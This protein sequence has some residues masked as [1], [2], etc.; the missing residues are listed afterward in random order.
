MNA[1]KVGA[2][3]SFTYQ[4]GPLQTLNGKCGGVLNG[5]ITS[6]GSSIGCYYVGGAVG[7]IFGA[8]GGTAVL[9]G[10]GSVVGAAE[11]ATGAAAALSALCGLITGDILQNVQCGQDANVLA[12]FLDTSDTSGLSSVPLNPPRITPGVGANSFFRV[13]GSTLKVCTDCSIVQPGPLP[14]CDGNNPCAALCA[15]GDCRSCLACDIKYV[16]SYPDPTSPT[17][18]SQCQADICSYFPGEKFPYDVYQYRGDEEA[19]C[20][21]GVQNTVQ[22]FKNQGGFAINAGYTCFA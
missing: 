16:S 18:C 11:G 17:G 1:N 10:P 22:Q 4:A 12:F 13:D 5:V 14:M 8:V 20:N 6:L 7:G 21:T 9:P 19:Y 15:N 2:T 3:Y